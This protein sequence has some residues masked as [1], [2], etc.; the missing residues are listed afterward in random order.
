L[1]EARESPPRSFL[2]KIKR[3]D[4]RPSEFSKWMTANWPSIFMLFF[5]F[6]LALFI[7]SYFGYE[8][9]ASN[10]YLVSGGSDS[11]YWQ[12]I[13]H[14][15][16]DTGKQMYWDP[17]I[18]FPDGIRNPRPPLFSM[19]IVVPAT[20]AQSMFGSLDD[21]LG[22]TLLWSTAFWGALTVVPTFFL[23][24]ETFGRRAGLVAAFFLAVMPSHVQRSVL[25]EAD[26]DSIILFSIVLTFYFILKAVKTQEHRRWVESWRSWVSIKSGLR[27]YFT[28]SKKPILYSLLAGV[29]YGAVIMTWVGFGYAT[30]LILVYYVI[31]V[32]LNKF[33]NFD[34]TSITLIVFIAMGFGFLMSFPVYYEQ[35]LIPVR[36]D[37]P[38]YLFLASIIFG[39]LFVVS[40]DYPWTLTFPAIIVLLVIGVLIVNVIDPALGQAILSGQGYFVQNKLY[41]TIAEAKAPVFSELALGF[42]MV[43][44]FMSLIGLI[45]ALLKVPK[46]ATTEYIFI[47]VWLGAAIFM[48]ISAARFMFNAAPAFAL[49]AGWVTVIMVDRLDFNSVRKSLMGASGSYLRIIR[50]SVKI[51]H[52]VGALFLAFLVVLPSVWYGTDAGI[53]SERKTAMDKQIYSSIPEFM[54]PS[55]YDK[56][57]GSNWYLGAFG[58][59]LPL[60]RY[61]FPAAWD[62][63]AQRDA[64]IVPDS[65]KPAYVSWWDYGFEAVQAGKHP[66]VADNFQNGY[67]LTGNVL[68]AQSEQEAIAIFA[69]R[70]IQASASNHMED[71]VSALLEKYGVDSKRMT[72]ILHGLG[73]PIIDEVLADPSTYGPM[74]SDLSDGNARIVAARVELSKIG[75]DRLVSLYGELCDMTGWSIR[76]FSV[77]SRMFPRS[78]Q[79]TG[80][81]YAP[82]KLSDRRIVDGSTPIDFFEIKAV[83][84]NGQQY[85]LD[86]VTSDMIIVDYAIDYKDMFYKS[87]LYR[88]MGGYMGT[89]IGQSNDGIPG[90]SG[91]TMSNYPGEPAWNL[92]HFRMVYRTTYYNP[93]PDPEYRDHPDAW[94]AISL[95]EAIAKKKLIDSGL[96]Q[97]VI[98][99]SASVV[100]SAGAVFLEYYKGAYV[101]GTLTTEEGDPVAGVR[102]TVQDEYGIPH[103]SV[104]TDG[105]G[106]YSLLAPFGNVT[107][108]MSTGD[109][110]NIG[111]AGSNVITKIQFNVTDD[112]AMRVNE[113]LDNNGVPDYI[114]TKDFKMKGSETTGDIFWDVN[115]DGNYTA[116]TDKLVPD[117]M[118]TA[119][120]LKTGRQYVINATDG[121][122]DVLLPPGQYDFEAYLFGSNV[123]MASGTNITAGAKSEQKLAVPVCGVVGDITYANGTPAADIGLI[124]TDLSTG[125]MRTLYTNENGTYVYDPIL[126]GHYVLTTNAPNDLLF[127]ALIDLSPSQVL[128]RNLTVFP[129]ATI[130]VQVI[131]GGSPAAYAVFMASN[132]YDPTEAI[133]GQADAFGWINMEVPRGSWTIYATYF[134]GAEAYVGASHFDASASSTAR[135]AITLSSAVRVT[136]SLKGPTSLSLA[137]EYVFFRLSNGARVPVKTDSS[138]VFNIQLPAGTYEVTSTSVKVKSLYSGI[139][140]IQGASSSPIVKLTRGALLQGSVWMDQ[141][142]KEGVSSADIGRFA[143]LK[144][145]GSDGIAFMTRSLANGSFAAVLPKDSPVVMTLG[146][147]G[148]SQWSQNSIATADSNS[149]VVA[150]PDNVIVEGQLTCNGEGI[151]GVTVAFLPDSFLMNPVYVRTGAY[152]MYSASLP[153]TSYRVVVEQ[154]TTPMGGERYMYDQS[155]QILPG[156]ES[157]VRNIQVVKRVEMYGFVTGASQDLK[158]TLQGPET[159]DITL[160][161]VNYSV[162]I[163]PGIYKVYGTGVVGSVHYAGMSTAVVSFSSRQHDLQLMPAYQVS[164][165]I[166][167]GSNPVARAA[168]VTATSLTG[169][170]VAKQSSTSGAY[171]IELPPGTYDISYLLETSSSSDGRTLYVEWYGDKTI[172]VESSSIALDASLVMRLDNTTFS[173]TVL[174]SSGAGQEAYV[175]LV[176]NT[177]FGLNASFYTSASGAFDVKVQPGDYTLYVTSLR[178]KRASLST[179]SFSRN[180]PSDNPIQLSDAKYLSG[181]VMVGDSGVALDVSV[182]RGNAK[183]HL[184]SG[185]DGSFIVLV[186]LGNCSVSASTSAV[187]RGVKVAY[188][189]SKTIAVGATD[190]Y[191]D[192]DL[193]R[194]TKWSV[195]SSWNANLTQAAKPGVKVV[196]SFTVTNTGNVAGL[197]L[198]TFVGTGFDVSFSP[199]EVWIEFGTD[200]QATIFAN[201]TAK[202]TTP[203]GQTKVDCLVRSRTTGSARSSIPLYM[204]VLKVN[205]VAVTS[206]D[207]SQPVSSRSSVTTFRLNNTGNVDD[208]FVVQV[209]NMD[210]LSAVGWTASIIDP[211][212]NL[213]VSEVSITAFG[214]KE[215]MVNFTMLRSSPDTEAKASVVAYSKFDP[216]ASAYGYVPVILPDLSVG[217]GSLQVV[218]GDVSYE[219]DRSALYADIA[220]V[221]SLAALFGAFLFLRK[222]KGSGG[223]GKK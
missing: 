100:Y 3:G 69:Y 93:Y 64:G 210:A 169:E 147:P 87:M 146:N 143:E 96:L 83:N 174:G 201:V 172:T 59:S 57:N 44:F 162:F 124:L 18:N 203:A 101:N 179:I 9:A 178:D 108:V 137:S 80:I 38:V 223:G 40:R 116:D 28:H 41:S 21:A 163:L 71:Q 16:A 209:A 135:G 206:L 106:Q 152:G 199:S 181:K 221:S 115:D 86:Q 131:L 204:N 98:D 34:S 205:G 8:M 49:A 75:L 213:T 165:M 10:G 65:E 117:V 89:D 196:Y 43:T 42:G 167:T 220:L 4:G 208:L 156:G 219:Y 102:V 48:A 197:F 171:T 154:D 78:G 133:T 103:G 15:S 47:V 140:T 189:A 67:Q 6:V 105:K 126:P 77:D 53:P 52:V 14:Y 142:A 200:N 136:G 79:D 193:A 170:S 177:K 139:V 214:S 61:Y 192:I 138:G 12:R 58:Y 23:G 94:Q 118:V 19:S 218:R 211:T 182:S 151:R 50:K 74:D 191:S 127:N 207:T 195:S 1:A 97:G 54:R 45:W 30:V 150:K 17:L 76:Y 60:P 129:R 132:D 155:V 82:A 123:S 33:K 13:I 68:M 114:I 121:T 183:L 113:D 184:T 112:Q 187:E 27:D 157:F 164:G 109:V 95:E 46:R 24:K 7:R 51:R 175:R 168:T 31:Q 153:P 2:S 37:V 222:K 188:S 122:F 119:K 84:Q 217:P 173:G 25:S 99:Q 120:D 149:V 92:T 70:L 145:T 20:I 66:T 148:Y 110:K 186:P 90:L 72:Q 73:Q 36:F 111:L 29:A 35:T 81:F 63:F 11:Y 134:T 128:V 198:V 202:N 22:W 166:R 159:R 190:V 32:V 85:S 88:A 144:V 161:S 194:D 91:Q 55:G 212:T 176:A 160:S 215:L 141:D 216:G 130:K 104:L 62:W 107:I 39:M 5:I 56:V 158:L 185:P 26:H 180:T 125:V